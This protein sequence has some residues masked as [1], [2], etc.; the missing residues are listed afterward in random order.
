MKGSMPIGM[1]MFAG[2]F[3]AV[4]LRRLRAKKAGRDF[5][6]LAAKLG[7]ELR[8]RSHGKGIGTVTGNYEGYR[9]YVDP[10]DQ[11]RITLQFETSPAIDLRSYETGGAAPRGMRSY[12]SGNKRFDAFFRTR[13]ASDELIGR[14]RAVPRLDELIEPFRGSYY[15]E[16]KQVN[17]THRGIS[18]VLDFGNPPHLPAAAVEQLLPAMA[19]LA[20]VI[21]PHASDPEP[22]APPPDSP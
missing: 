12:F 18:C 6:D 14:L 22:P 5:P 7:L 21:E 3:L 4:V 19:K 16:L 8:P 10:E 20:S 11:R 17:V 15:R 2:M 13:F 9:I 1:L